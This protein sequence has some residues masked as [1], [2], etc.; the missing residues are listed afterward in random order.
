M[1][2]KK[3]MYTAS[4]IDKLIASAQEIGYEILTVKEGTL[5]YGVTYLIAPEGYYNYIVEEKYIN[6]W[7]GG[8]TISRRKNITA[9]MRKNIERL[10][11]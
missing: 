2:R 1:A 5:G 3:K 7:N 8:H 6:S 10:T 9:E 4:A 11:A